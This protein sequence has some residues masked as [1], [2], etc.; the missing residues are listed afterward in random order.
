MTRSD[1]NLFI[2]E[3]KSYKEEEYRKFSLKTIN[4]NYE[5]LG[6]RMKYLD[7][8]SRKIDNLLEFYDLVTFTYYEEVMILGFVIAKCK[9]INYLKKF[10]KKIDNWAI[11]DGVVTRF[12]LKDKE[13][14]S[15]LT[16]IK[17]FINSKH[18]FTIRLGYVFLL[19]YYVKDEYLD[20]I[21]QLVDENKN[22]AYYVEMAIAW[23][24]SYCYLYNKD[25]TLRFLERSNLDKFTYNKTISK[26]RESL[27]VGKE[28]K[29]YLR[30]LL[31]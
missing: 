18:E 4:T 28:E 5:V 23:L 1:Y 17:E 26:I 13:L 14:D 10:A 15:F 19:N 22:D 12:K 24:L 20:T 21:F 25:K 30:T 9:N 31:R 27:R 11:C 6:V 29:I 3:L 8:L 7:K 16:Y 2:E